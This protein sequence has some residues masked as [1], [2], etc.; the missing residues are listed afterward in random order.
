M[1]IVLCT[2]ARAGPRPAYIVLLQFYSAIFYTYILIRLSINVHAT[3]LARKS[4]VLS[5]HPKTGTKK[6]TF[7]MVG[8]SNWQFVHSWIGNSGENVRPHSR[9]AYITWRHAWFLSPFLWYSF[10]DISCNNIYPPISMSTAPAFYINHLIIM[11]LFASNRRLPP[12]T[13]PHFPIPRLTPK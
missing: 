3:R 8:N 13:V 12:H 1:D 4:I 10:P 9:T 11:Q 6:M 7:R 2:K 5:L